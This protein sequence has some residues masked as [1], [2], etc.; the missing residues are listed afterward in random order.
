VPS[1]CGGPKCAIPIA[2][3]VVTRR[4]RRGF[5]RRSVRITE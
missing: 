4:E 5:A 1:A 2:E 3:G